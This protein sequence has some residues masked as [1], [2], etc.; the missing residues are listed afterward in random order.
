VN[1]VKGNIR[2]LAR[3]SLTAG[4]ALSLASCAAVDNNRATQPGAATSSPAGITRSAQSESASVISA[5]ELAAQADL[6]ERQALIDEINRQ[7]QRS[8]VREYREAAPTPLQAPQQNVV[9]LNYEQADLREVLAELA[10]AL[11]MTIVIDPAIAD[12]VS[13]RTAANR[14]LT[15]EDIWPLMRLLSREHGVLL[16]RVGNMYYARRGDSNLPLEITTRQTTSSGSASELMQIT[17][18]TYISMASALELLAPL[19]EPAGR[20]VRI[21]NS[22]TLAITGTRSQLARVNELLDLID[23]DPFRNQGIQLYPLSNASAT[24]VAQELRDVLFLVEGASPA[25]QVQGLDRINALLVTA[26]ASR[27]FEEISRWI[28]ILDADRQEQAEQL[29]RYRVKNLNA[30]DLAT[31]LGEVFRREENTSAGG[32]SSANAGPLGST[33]ETVFLS[34]TGQAMVTPATSAAGDMTVSADLRVSIVADEATNSL[35]IRANPRDYRQLLATINQ[36]DT[37]PLQVMINAVIA[38]IVLTDDTAFGVDWSRVLQNASSGSSTIINTGF[39]PPRGPNQASAL[40]GLLFNRAFIDGAARVEAT[41]EAIAVNND[42]RLLARPSLTVVNNMEG[43]ISIGS[44]VPVRVGETIGLGGTST[45]NIQ[46]RQTGIELSITPRINDDGVVNLLIRQ[47]LSSVSE[48]SGVDNNPI[49][50]NQ[51]IETT[52]VVRDGENVV[53]GGLIQNSN[54][55]L[56]TGVPLLNR[57]P[58]LGRL[59][60]YQR[61][62]NERRELFIVI[63][64]EIIN[65]NDQNDASFREVLSRFELAAELLQD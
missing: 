65:V 59:F 27:G 58:G 1:N 44:D 21:S 42:V 53:L 23:D 11:D 12:R 25:Y 10:D 36:L 47:S 41:L 19:V 14:P 64:P 38:Q 31:T 34:A 2:Q 48:G 16:E 22:N 63:R 33:R 35:L 7:G 54:D 8:G 9:E 50:Q 13:L 56:N 30:V 51:V 57:V 32:A 62:N 5:R 28:R 39:L 49:F 4:L 61:D 52:V 55:L 60:S 29:F 20:V 40:G 43:E 45:T 6:Q 37:A 15:Y 3:T 46:Y 17:P 24:D 26:P 18:L